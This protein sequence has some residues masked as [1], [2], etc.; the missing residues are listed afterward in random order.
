MVSN[1]VI[2][3]LGMALLVYLGIKANAIASNDDEAGFLLGGRSF[4]PFVAAGTIMATGFSGWCFVGA[5][6][7]V[8][9]FGFTEVLANF[10][11]GLSITAAILFFGNYLRQRAGDIG[12]LTLPE[13]IRQHHQTSEDDALGRVTQGLA[14]TLN[15]VLMTVFIVAQTKALGLVCSNWLGLSFNTAAILMLVIIIAYTATGGLAAVAWTDVI[16]VLGMAVG[17][18]FIMFQIFGDISLSDLVTKM[19]E[20]DPELVNPSSGRPYG[21]SK[22]GPFLVAPYAFMFAAVLPY[23]CVRFLGV[24]KDAKWRHIAAI[25]VPLGIV[26]SLIPIVGAYV[27]VKV[28]MG[29]IPPLASADLAMPTYL[30]NFMPG[31]IGG[32]ITL[33]I[34]FAMG[35]TADSILQVLSASVSHDLRKSITGK[36]NHSPKTIRII[37][38]SS[39]VV[40]GIMG[41]L[42]MLAAPPAFLNFIS[43]LGTGTLQSAMAGPVFIGT[44]WRGN[45]IGAIASMLGGAAT[46]AILLL[47]TDF[48]W[49]TSPLLGDVVGITLY[50]VVS[51][52]TFGICQR[53]EEV[54]PVGV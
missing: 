8:Y 6:G 42:A 37:N 20:I 19:N 18:V 40:M 34:V 41:F 3:I 26:L 38:R 52:L 49:V 10:F 29:V 17:C 30:A 11:F 14:A 24:R 21:E 32:I 39:V 15:I 9:E 47:Y 13:Y 54:A 22:I 28:H 1:W 43:I 48:G 27:R 50:F 35:S 36:A 4:G 33:F 46:T 7:V 31:I 45:M 2:M 51:M 5:P 16:M 23:M 25:S 44:I 53:R 12:S